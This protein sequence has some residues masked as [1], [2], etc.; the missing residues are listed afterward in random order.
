MPY[1][2]RG[3]RRLFEGYY[4]NL[5]FPTANFFIALVTSATAP[6]PDI[7]TFSELTEI[8]AGNGYTSGGGTEGTV[9]RNATDF[10]NLTENDT[11]D[12]VEIQIIDI[13]WT[14]SGGPIP[15]SGN[16]ARW[17][18]MLDDNGTVGSREVLAWWDLTEDRQVS[19][20]QSL[21]LQDLELR[22]LHVA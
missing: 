14:A 10:E 3:K 19:S 20:G 7:N 1:T 13:V 16:P 2:N 18:V 15:A 8:G 9:N 6:N 4:Q 17:A 5:A 12:R 11:S 22:G 21:T